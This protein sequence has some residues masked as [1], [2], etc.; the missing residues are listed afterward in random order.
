MRGIESNGMILMAEDAA[1]QNTLHQSRSRDW[2][3]GNSQLK[4]ECRDKI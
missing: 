1:T 3:R 2:R 4:E